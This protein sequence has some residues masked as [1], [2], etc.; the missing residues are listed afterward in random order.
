MTN[1]WVT[2]TALFSALGAF[3]FGLD[4][5]YI[6]PILQCPSFKRDVL[7]L[8][9]WDDPDSEVLSGLEGFIVGIFSVGCILTSFPV[10]S[11]YFL[12]SWGRKSSITC[13]AAVFL[14]GCVCQASASSIGQMLLG[15][16][17]AGCSIGLLSAI[18]S[19]YQSE[20]APPKLRGSLTSFYNLMITFG[21]LVAAFMDLALVDRSGGWRVAIWLQAIPALAIICGMP[22]LS[23]SPRWLVQQGRAEDALSALQSIRA[24]GEAE[25]EL[26]EILQEHKAGQAQGT[27][28]WV[29]L[30]SGRVA[31]LL[32]VGIGLQLLQQ[33]VGINAFMYFG[34][35]VFGQ[36][37]LDE[38]LFQTINNGV[39]FLSTFPAIYLVDTFGRRSLLILGAFG[40]FV[41]CSLMGIIGHLAAEA[42]DDET[43]MSAGAYATVAMIFL[44]VFSFAASWGPVAWVYC[45]EMFPLKHRSRCIGLSTTANWVGNYIIAQIT[46]LLF[47]SLGFGTFFVFAFFSLLA[48]CL[49]CWLPETK[50]V[51]LE[52]IDELF[53]GKFAG[54]P[55]SKLK[56]ERSPGK[57]PSKTLS[58]GETEDDSVKVVARDT[59]QPSVVGAGDGSPSDIVAEE[60]PPLY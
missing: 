28:Q 47:D 58:L 25:S 48:L 29:E 34:P 20:V 26:T 10:V 2:C 17:V 45:A 50:G 46:P 49:A 6:A 38:N 55:Y 21:I 3:L 43:T 36:L 1:V 5:G 19:L 12:D 35:R 54:K 41:A 4:I 44:F 15:R 14:V 40:M 18:V 52:R 27:A 16:F 60:A 56:P 30:V 57:P 32:A 53:D 22:L 51:V 7:H 31:R 8:V 59:V 11:G 23:E 24:E 13:G 33:L 39:N 9:D 37:G 42:A